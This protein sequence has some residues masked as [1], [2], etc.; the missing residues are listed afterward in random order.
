MPRTPHYWRASG[1]T[2]LPDTFL[3][4]DS[5]TQPTPAP[6][7]LVGEFHVLRLGVAMSFR[8]ERGRR[9]RLSEVVYHSPAE[10]WGFVGRRLSA[11]RP[12]WL[13]AHNLAFD[14]GTVDGWNRLSAPDCEWATAIWE[15]GTF[16]FRGTMGGKPLVLCDTTNYYKCPLATVGKAVGL[17]KMPMP[18]F[19]D[20]DSAWLDYCRN[21]VEVTARGIEVLLD[22]WREHDLGPWCPTIAS[23]AFSAY[24]RRFLFPKCLVHTDRSSLRLERAAYYGGRVDTPFIGTAPASPVW[25]F[26][27]ASLYPSTYRNPLPYYYLGAENDPRPDRVLC[28]GPGVHRVADV[29]LHTSEEPY[30]VRVRHNVYHP[31]GRFRTA[32]AEP[33]FAYA[34]AAGHVKRVHRVQFYKAAPIFERYLDY[35]YSLK[36]QYEKGGNIAFRTVTKYLMNSLYGKTGQMSPRWLPYGADA[37]S[38]LALFHGLPADALEQYSG[39]SH[40]FEGLSAPW[41]LPE[42]PG[43]VELRRC[44]GQLEI[45]VARWESR[46][47]CPAIAATVT[48]YGRLRLSEAQR[49]A[50][51]GNWYYSDTDSIWVDGEGRNNLL[52]SGLV[53]EGTAGLLAAG[54]EVATLTVH[55]R[56]DYEFTGGRRLK[57][58][59]AGVEPDPEGGYHQLHFPSAHVQMQDRLAGGVFVREV[60]KTLRRTVDWCT[61]TP[62]GFTEPLVFPHECP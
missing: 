53:G 1:R 16:F 47:S 60:V 28:P 48:S 42:V 2:A 31:V 40:H 17:P 39:L 54:K 57:G 49:A 19:A 9:T 58:I 25:E 11:D 45:Q 24:R 43:V 23:L 46:D 38:Q 7:G 29:T 34:V 26:D 21:D 44:W 36:D 20:S 35:F 37:L 30:P 59:R 41:T 8:L 18:A 6:R 10:F 62:T 61:R 32:L 14:L 51:R 50:G 13:L 3:V 56:K 27:F 12:L 22:F 15:G 5:E 52:Q 4:F 33:E 55:G